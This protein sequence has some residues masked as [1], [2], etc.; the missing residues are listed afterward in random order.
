[1]PPDLSWLDHPYVR[2]FLGHYGCSINRHEWA[3]PPWTSTGYAC[4]WCSKE[5]TDAD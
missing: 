1:M 4:R 2:A 5:R 3:L